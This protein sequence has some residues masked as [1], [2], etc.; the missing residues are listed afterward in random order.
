MWIPFRIDRLRL[1]EIEVQVNGQRAA[2]VVD[3]GATRTVFD[4]SFVTQA[5]IEVRE[6]FRGNGLTSALSGGLTTG[7]R[8]DIAGRRLPGLD[9]AVLDLSAI[10]AALGHKVDVVLG[11]ELFAA[12]LV[13]IDFPRNRLRL[14]APGAELEAGT[15]VQLGAALDRLRTLPAE[16]P[17]DLGVNA[18]LDLGSNIALYIDP[19][20]AER[21]RLL[22]RLRTSTSAS[23]GAEGIE[24]STVAVLPSVTIA[25]IRLNNVP[26]QIP[27]RWQFAS[28]ALVGLPIL[29]RFRLGLDFTN[30]RA[31]IDPEDSLLHLPFPKDRSGLGAVPARGRL[32]VIHVAPGSPAERIGLAA[33]DEITAINGRAV[34]EAFLR[35]RPRIGQGPPGTEVKLSLADGDTHL[36]VLE[37]YF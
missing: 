1:I 15:P 26:V 12:G 25:G 34:D 30:S 7:T 18:A 17:G 3:T 32:Q 24:V 31:W 6:G 2:A 23:A 16:L 8:I 27:Q 14:L 35:Q 4:R 28:Q 13:E 20:L 37:D 11:Q 19:A 9:A 5:G 21:H 10:S 36:M 29:S 22:E 33:G